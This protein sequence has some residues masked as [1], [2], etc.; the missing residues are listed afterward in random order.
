MSSAKEGYGL[1]VMD[2]A[3]ERLRV[4]LR[5]S[6]FLLTFLGELLDFFETWFLWL[7]G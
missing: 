2:Y 1:N 4:L 5:K 6:A 3:G 7:N